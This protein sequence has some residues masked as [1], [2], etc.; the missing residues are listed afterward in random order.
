MKCGSGRSSWKN[1]SDP[2][3][4]LFDSSSWSLIPCVSSWGHREQRPSMCKGTIQCLSQLLF[5]SRACFPVKEF[6]NQWIGIKTALWLQ[7]DSRSQETGTWIS[8]FKSH[9]SGCC[10]KEGKCVMQQDVPFTATV[11]T[12]KTALSCYKTGSKLHSFLFWNSK[13][14][15]D[16]LLLQNVLPVHFFLSHLLHLCR[17]RINCCCSDLVEIT[18]RLPEAGANQMDQVCISLIPRQP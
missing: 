9:I 16:I 5:Q 2:I 10:S 15:R 8:N 1:S 17:L 3:Q 7:Q 4:A 12:W 14:A 11:F 6:H 18:F 13:T